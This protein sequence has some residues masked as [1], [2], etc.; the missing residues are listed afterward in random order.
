[1]KMGALKI[2][3]AVMLLICAVQGNSYAKQQGNFE[4]ITKQSLVDRT[5]YTKEEYG[6]VKMQFIKPTFKSFDGDI[7]FTILGS[8]NSNRGDVEQLS[9]RIDDGSIIYY[10][11]DGAKYRMTLV[12]STSMSWIVLE[13]EDM[14][15]DGNRQGYAR[16]VKKI[17]YLDRPNGYPR[18]QD[19][20]PDNEGGCSL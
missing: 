7:V 18:F 12:S 5:L 3:F 19:C 8:Q 17:Y 2:I 20:K 11:H 9:Y 4:R 15:G 16:P 14:D 10:S 6:Y 13:E 1:M